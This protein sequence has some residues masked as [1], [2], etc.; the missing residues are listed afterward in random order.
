[1]TAMDQKINAGHLKRNAFLYIR[2]STVRQVMENTESTKRQYALRQ[3]AAALG[4][5]QE[6]IIV[7]DSDLGQSA[8]SASDREGFQKLVTEV[9]LGRAGIVLGLEVSRLARNSA[10]WHRLLEICALT[11]TLILDE[12]GIYDPAHFNDRLLLGLK[13]TMS[14]AELHVLQARMRGGLINKAKRGELAIP[15]PIG[16]VYNDQGQV[17]LDPDQQVQQ[18]IHYFFTTF[19]RTG[20]LVATVKTFYREGLKFPMR[21]LSGPHCGEA[22]WVDLERTRARYLLH[23]P[24]YAGAYVYG[25]NRSRNK[26]DGSGRTSWR[27]P[28]EQW[29]VVLAN[30]HAGYISWEDYEENVR[31]LRQNAQAYGS[32]RPKG[33]AREGPALLQGLVFCGR[34]GTRMMVRYHSRRGHRFPDYICQEKRCRRGEP[35]C[36]HIPGIRVDE[37]IAELLLEVVTPMS[38]ALTLTVQQEVQNQVAEADRLRQIQV[39]RARYE[40]NL[41]QRR[42]MQVDPDNRLV[43]DSLEADWNRKLRALAEAQEEY[44]RQ[45]KAGQ[46]VLSDDQRAEILTLPVNFPQLWKD[47][48]TPDRERKRIVRLMLEDVTLLR[49]QQIHVQIRFKGGATRTLCV[50][51]PPTATKMRNTSTEVISAIDQLLNQHS[52]GQIAAILNE[53]GFLTGEGNPFDAHRVGVVERHYSLKGRIL[54]LREAGLITAAELARLLNVTTKAVYRLYREGRLHA[55]LCDDSPHYLYERPAA[56]LMAQLQACIGNDLPREAQYE[57]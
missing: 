48:N 21:P 24:R 2:Q 4:W 22:L 34:C 39:E 13:G 25:R 30:A 14:E 36:Q 52:R 56:E 43:A 5:P 8:A 33:P 32:E 9:S 23:N 46:R 20:S 47:P 38:L 49:D 44:E 41:A 42:F 54:R 7:I 12:D 19:R 11:D 3:R 40:A 50:P 17:V 35:L 29:Q 27:L 16:F 57:E 10:D 45:S 37:A 55:E 51:I 31:R 26:V 28:R 6:Q 53:R 1:M 15:L 18:S